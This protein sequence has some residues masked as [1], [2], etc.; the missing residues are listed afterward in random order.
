MTIVR[1]H[2]NRNRISGALLATLGAL[3]AALLASQAVAQHGHPLVG[4]WSGDWG[5]TAAERT[6]LLLTL[7]FSVDQEISGFI[8]ENGVRIPLRSANLDPSTWTVTM[9]AERE[10]ADGITTQYDIEGKIENLGSATQRRIA[11][12]W[13][14]GD[15][16]GDFSVTIN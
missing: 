6:R 13:R 3:L 5:P 1:M 7:E 14:K 9:T 2:A 15:R 8:Y 12:V 16:S 4:S 10:S 11:G